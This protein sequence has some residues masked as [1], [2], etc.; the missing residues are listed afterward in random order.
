MKVLNTNGC[1]EMY[2]NIYNENKMFMRQHKEDSK[3]FRIPKSNLP[4]SILIAGYR[5]VYTRK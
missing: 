2:I 1:L 5:I 3:I 4:M